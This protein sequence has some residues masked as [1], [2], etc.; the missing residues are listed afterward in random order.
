MSSDEPRTRIGF[1]VSGPLGQR[2]FSER[3]LEAL[4][5]QALD[6]G[7]VH[8]DTGAF[9]SGAEARLG[10]ALKAYGRAGIFI[11]TKTGTRREG[12]RLVKDF[13]ETAI[14]ADVAESLR[15]L[16]RDCLDL[17]Y[18]HGPTSDEMDAARP[19][20]AALKREGKIAAIGVC[21]EGAP[22]IRAIETGFDAVMAVYNVID[23]RYE[24]TFATAKRNGLMTVAIAPLAQGLF[25]PK[26]FMP[27]TPSDIWRLS[28]AAFRRRYRRREI[29]AFRSALADLGRLDPA[30]AAL[31]FVLA[32]SDI[33]IVMTTTTKPRHLAQSLAAARKP[34][35]PAAYAALK[36]LSLDPDGGGA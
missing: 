32:N 34:P 30:D 4:I 26:F 12:R 11:S 33:D 22:L 8:F 36:S 35:D 1:G 9:Y 21:G 27:S 7:V 16:D 14:R 17:L 6:G 24:A 15:R 2:W 13:S 10:A 29:D 3:K 18:L 5:G 28:R 31:G 20:L 23:R 25:D 19:V